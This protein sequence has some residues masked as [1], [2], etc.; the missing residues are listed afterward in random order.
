MVLVRRADPLACLP[1]GVAV[2]SVREADRS[3]EAP[4]SI[5][6]PSSSTRAMEEALG[7]ELR[8]CLWVIAHNL[9]VPLT[10]YPD[11]SHVP[12]LRLFEYVAVARERDEL[13]R[14]EGRKKT[15]ALTSAA[16]RLGMEPDTARV[17]L[18]S[19]RTAARKG[20]EKNEQNVDG[21]SEG[22]G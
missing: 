10:R 5:L 21:E 16:V 22:G 19:I 20:H 12:A 2:R 8:N 6:E 13:V 11:W 18:G 17:R 7:P 4:M 3:A 15:R 14:E 1:R 9:G